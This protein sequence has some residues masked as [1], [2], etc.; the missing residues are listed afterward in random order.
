M[1]EE[2]A[3]LEKIRVRAEAALAN[4]VTVEGEIHGFAKVALDD[5]RDNFREI[6]ALASGE[7]HCQHQTS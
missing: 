2:K 7:R 4:L 3:K 5:A 1:G 6:L